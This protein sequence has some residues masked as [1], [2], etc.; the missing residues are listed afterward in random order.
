MYFNLDTSTYFNGIIGPHQL[1]A[2][3]DISQSP[4]GIQGHQKI[5]G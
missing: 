2:V 5:R 4:K 1:T 3:T